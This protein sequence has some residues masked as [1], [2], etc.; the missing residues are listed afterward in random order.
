[1]FRTP[2]SS[3]EIKV[4]TLTLVSIIESYSVSVLYLRQQAGE[5]R[6]V[7]TDQ[8]STQPGERVTESEF[9]V[10]FGSIGRE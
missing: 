7:K 9:N 5:Q 4:N 1:M 6:A 8:S 2:V 3:E 10:Q